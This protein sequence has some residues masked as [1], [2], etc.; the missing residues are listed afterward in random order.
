LDKTLALRGVTYN[1]IED[2]AEKLGV[3]AQEVQTIIPEVVVP[4]PNGMLA[5]DY[6]NIVGLLIEAIKELKAEVD[7]LKN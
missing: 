7:L 2:N 5:V 6:G 1:R 4:G 3:I